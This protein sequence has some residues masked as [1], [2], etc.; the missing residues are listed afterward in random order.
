MMMTRS[1]SLSF[2]SS[3]SFPSLSAACFVL[4]VSQATIGKFSSHGDVIK[5]LKVQF[6][7]KIS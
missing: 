6:D 7:G 3:S 4:E 5:L 1:Y 2:G